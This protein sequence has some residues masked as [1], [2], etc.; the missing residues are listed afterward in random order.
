[1]AGGVALALLFAKA[2]SIGDR[3][4]DA[5]ADLRHEQLAP[6]TS[7]PMAPGRYDAPPSLPISRAVQ[8]DRASPGPSGLSRPQEVIHEVRAGDTLWALSR[9]YYGDPFLWP[10]IFASNRQ[11]INNPDLI[12]PRERLRIPLPRK[13]RQ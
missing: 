12:T 13:G 11:S 4:G 7:A 10:E 6:P 1:V 9:R 8:A 2:A 5:S 3:P